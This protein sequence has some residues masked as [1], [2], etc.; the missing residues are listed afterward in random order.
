MTETTKSQQISRLSTPPFRTLGRRLLIYVM[1]FSGLI[2]LIGAALQLV[3]EYQ[4]DIGKIHERLEQIETS[5][6]VSLTH[7]LWVVDKEQIQVQ[8]QGLLHLPD[9]ERLEV[10]SSGKVIEV[11][12]IPE[13]SKR[14]SRSYPMVQSFKGQNFQLGTLTVDVNLSA[15]YERLW[16]QFLVILGTQAVKTTLVSIFILLMFHY[17]LTRHISFM[18]EFMSNLEETDV[19]PPLKLNR[20]P[21]NKR[22]DELDLL[23][24]ALNSMRQRV[25]HSRKLLNRHLDELEER[26]Q[27]RTQRL[28]EV[29]ETLRLEI[30]ERKKTAKALVVAKRDAE[31]ANHAKSE[32][33]ATMSH[34][35]RTPLSGIL[36][37]VRLLRN[38]EPSSKQDQW[39]D[40]LDLA[41]QNLATLLTDILD[42]SKIESGVLEMDDGL[43][44]LPETVQQAISAATPRAIKKEILLNLEMDDALPKWLW[45]DRVKLLQVM[46]NL[47]GNAI[48][49][50]HGGSVTLKV[51]KESGHQDKM[52]YRFEVIDTGVG[53]D[54]NLSEKLFEPFFQVE[55]NLNQ[56]SGGTGLGLAICHR[57]VEGM[58]GRIGVD[59]TPGQ[60]STFWFVAPFR[61]AQQNEID[62]VKM[63]SGDTLTAERSI[64]ILL[65]EDNPIIMEGV[66][67]LLELDAHQV[68]T[69]SN[70]LQALER[71]QEGHFDLVLM[72]VRMPGMDGLETTR[73]LRALPLSSDSPL[74]IIGLT[75]DVVQENLKRCLASGMNQVLTKP[76]R[77]ER[78]KKILVEISKSPPKKQE[79]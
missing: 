1:L 46:T 35:L 33:V 62:S 3:V 59:S 38:T 53:I 63:T 16:K 77:F 48:K 75:G 68:Q 76:L 40:Y 14:L 67:S 6:L 19:K 65:V 28:T 71:Y 22:T 29:N 18:A 42:L 5:Y 26:V 2:T 70:G 61:V 58:G 57:M 51:S 10:R 37:M 34:E 25:R 12:E 66:K 78:L 41:G 30:H 31:S 79:Q 11:G 9:I 32:F 27:E 54:P 60:G 23:T 4:T 7:S 43:F 50:T 15:V 17:L 49:F 72:D 13:A 21:S 64:S 74:T 44:N 55:T 47:V 73:R 8:M 52:S 45:G 69:A 36:D 39:L 56:H 24:N 20:V